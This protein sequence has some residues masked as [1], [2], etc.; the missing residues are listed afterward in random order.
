MGGQQHPSLLR[1]A[2]K[3]IFIAL[4]RKTT[5][6]RI[7]HSSSNT[8]VSDAAPGR[9]ASSNP[10]QP[11]LPS[12]HARPDTTQDLLKTLSYRVSGSRTAGK[13]QHPNATFPAA[14]APDAEKA[15]STVSSQAPIAYDIGV[16]SKQLSTLAS[17][18][19]RGVS[20]IG[21]RAALTFAETERH[22][23]RES[24]SVHRGND[25]VFEGLKRGIL[26]KIAK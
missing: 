7:H 5:M 10:P 4:A 16:L 26:T 8:P 25:E 18:A 12:S 15:R 22:K 23:E 9:D 19:G 3:E 6:I 13:S 1:L 24:L 2:R 11:P 21:T 14:I 17:F 20:E